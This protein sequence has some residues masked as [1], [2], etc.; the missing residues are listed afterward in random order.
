[1]WIIHC[2]SQSAFDVYLFRRNPIEVVEIHSL[3]YDEW[4]SR[5]TFEGNVSEHPPSVFVRYFI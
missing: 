1:M 2:I 3:T 4:Y 5:I